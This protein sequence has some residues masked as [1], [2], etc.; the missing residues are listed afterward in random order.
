MNKEAFGTVLAV[1]AAVI[2]GFAIPVNK[3]FVVGIDPLVF[4]AVRALI[5]GLVFLLLAGLH[6]KYAKRKYSFVKWKQGR[7]QW[8]C[9]IAIGI[10]GGGLA[11][12]MF[13]TGLKLTT[14]GRAAFLHKT[15]PIYACAFAAVFLKERVPRKQWYALLAML[16]G[17]FLIYFANIPL[18]IWWT[19]PGLGDLLVIGATVLWAAENTIA[20]KVMREGESNFIVSFSRMFIGA[21]LLFAVMVLMGRLDVLL[22]LSGQQV[23]NLFISTAFLF[24]Y[25]LFWY[26]SLR[27]I[28]L[29]KAATLLLLAPV[30][31]MVAGIWWFGELFP[32]MQML[33]SMLILAG[34]WAVIRIKSTSR[35]GPRKA[36]ELVSGV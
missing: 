1:M 24:G 29:S 22:A 14:V 18:T 13:F 3:V 20:R 17:T 19:N 9:M 10:I 33:G 23:F 11:F 30:I 12:L 21:I 2:S 25:V 31:S 34:A 5:I 6:N 7:V 27:Y 32:L 36:R 28:S 15:L 8:K 4:T 35:H 16:A 26:W